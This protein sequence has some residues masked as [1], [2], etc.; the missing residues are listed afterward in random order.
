MS[1][2]FSSALCLWWLC[3]ALLPA[4]VGCAQKN[5]K[6]TSQPAADLEKVGTIEQRDAEGRIVS[7]TFSLNRVSD[8]DLK[9][10]TKF[11][12]LRKLIIQ[13]CRNV[14]DDSLQY[15]V[16]LPRLREL[17]FMHTPITDDGLS[18]LKQLQ[19][20]TALSL[21]STE[22][23]G[24]GLSHLVE[25]KLEKLHLAGMSWTAEGLQELL[26]LNKL[27]ELSLNCPIIA[28]SE[29]PSLL[30]L[31]ELQ[32]LN[33][34]AVRF[35]DQSLKKVSGLPSLQFLDL[36][37]EDLTNTG[38]AELVS[39]PELRFLR[40]TESQVTND[41]LAVL[42]SLKKFKFIVLSHLINDDGLK[43]LAQVSSLEHIDG[44]PSALTGEGM[45]VLA[46]LPKISMIELNAGR[47]TAQGRREIRE[48]KK[49]KPQCTFLLNSDSGS[50]E[51]L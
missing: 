34:R 33:I 1:R 43:H 38:L 27:K 16:Q 7:I 3:L 14:S 45:T 11:T 31:Q 8:T 37:V 12:H 9:G 23:S 39:S 10:I 25:L 48:F 22:M 19:G 41:G 49:S 24:T 6:K 30:S 13:E 21:I 15:I 42:K 51:E 36:D 35:D 4:L 47:V 18:H 26:K 2:N 50:F 46:N 17:S 5:E 20:L 29:M 28:L 40:L 44:T 32:K